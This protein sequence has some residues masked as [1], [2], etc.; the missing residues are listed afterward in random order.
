MLAGDLKKTILSVITRG[1]TADKI[2]AYYLKASIFQVYVK[3]IRVKLHNDTQLEQYT[4]AYLKIYKD[5]I[6]SNS[7]NM[8]ALNHELH[9]IG[10]VCKNILLFT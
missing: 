4:S 10:I 2:N 3:K 7:N 6:A 8:I 1:T 9:K 5:R